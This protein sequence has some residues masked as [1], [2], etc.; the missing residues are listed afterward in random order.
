[1]KLR[2]RE[3]LSEFLSNNFNFDTRLGRTRL[4]LLLSPGEI[5]KQ[6]NAGKRVRYV[7]P[8]QLYLFVSFLYFLL[9]GLT[10]DTVLDRG[11]SNTAEA[12]ATVNKSVIG[13]KVNGLRWRWA[14]QTT[15]PLKLTSFSRTDHFR[16]F[17][18]N[19][20]IR[21]AHSFS[22]TPEATSVFG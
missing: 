7:R 17:L 20:I 9:L 13:L 2:L 18:K 3:L 1:M 16:F 19:S 15:C 22:I 11:S 21:L 6:F 5:T 8:L 10:T 4:D 14:F 12:E